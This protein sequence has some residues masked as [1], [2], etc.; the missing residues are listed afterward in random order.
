M[1]VYDP[2]QPPDPKQWLALTE[3][4]RVELVQEFHA[5]ALQEL[6]DHDPDEG[7]SRNTLH[8]TIHVVVETQLAQRIDPVCQTLT[9][10]MNEGLGRHDAIHAIGGELA[11]YL[12]DALRG[13]TEAAPKKFTDLYYD[14]LRKRKRVVAA[15]L[16]PRGCPGDD[17]PR[18][19]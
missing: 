15:A 1:E 4:E 13:G 6:E 9:R 18:C 8:A 11:G 10:L 17:M 3:S 19:A 14:R 12:F 16:R 5:D 2:S 7:L